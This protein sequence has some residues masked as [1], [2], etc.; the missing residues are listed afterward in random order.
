MAGDVNLAI[1]AVLPPACCGAVMC[2]VVGAEIVRKLDGEWWEISWLWL[3]LGPVLL[4]SGGQIVTGVE[5]KDLNRGRT[6]LRN[7]AVRHK[8]EVFPTVEEAV[9]S[10]I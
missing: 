1:L 6:Y 3:F 9:A 8:V 4:A 5:L 2:L 10:L 7:L